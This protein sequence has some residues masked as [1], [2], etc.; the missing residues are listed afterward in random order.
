MMAKTAMP[1]IRHELLRFIEPIVNG[2]IIFGG[3]TEATC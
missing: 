2:E 3:A 1:K